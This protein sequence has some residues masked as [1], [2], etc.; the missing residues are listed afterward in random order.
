[1]SR[2]IPVR[3]SPRLL[4]DS[5]MNNSVDNSADD[6][7]GGVDPQTLAKA[8]QAALKFLSYRN[9]SRAEVRR[10]L[11]QRYPSEVV[12]QVITR[13]LEQNYLDDAAFAIEWRRQR[14]RRRPRGQSQLRKEL[15]GLGVDREVIQDALEGIAET[16]NA[17]NAASAIVRRLTNAKAGSGYGVF[18]QKLWAYLQRRGF[19]NSAIRSTVERYTGE[20]THLLDGGVATESKDQPAQGPEQ[21]SN[22]DSGDQESADDRS[23]GDPS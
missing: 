12:E 19:D 10:K 23:A 17:Y 22:D 20:L 3:I 1:M 18:R 14:E 15:L 9:R 5:S 13:L 21:R 7:A 11:S 16:D 2:P 4:V 6:S 8:R